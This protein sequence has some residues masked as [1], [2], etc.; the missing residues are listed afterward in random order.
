MQIACRC[1]QPFTIPDESFPHRV[2]CHTCGRH[3]LALSDGDIIDIDSKATPID[4]T[5]IQVAHAIAAGRAPNSEFLADET[6]NR[7]DQASRANAQTRLRADLHVLDFMW[8]TER[9][10]YSLVPVIGIAILPTT[11]LTMIFAVLF[12]GFWSAFIGLAYLLGWRD[13]MYSAAPAVAISTYIPVHI[14]MKTHE[15]EKA[16]SEWQRK[17]ALAIAKSG[18]DVWD[19]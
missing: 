19:V 3:F 16:K 2:G 10:A 7:I 8:N 11:L 17:R 14:Y 6:K 5:A 12:G 18:L 1:G 13:W 9:E 15:Y 4:L